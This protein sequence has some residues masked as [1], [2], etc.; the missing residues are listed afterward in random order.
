[1]N[2]KQPNLLPHALQNDRNDLPMQ[3]HSEQNE[4]SVNESESQVCNREVFRTR[5]S[6]RGQKLMHKTDNNKVRDTNPQPANNSLEV[7]SLDML[8]PP[9]GSKRVRKLKTLPKTERPL[10]QSSPIERMATGAPVISATQAYLKPPDWSGEAKNSLCFPKVFGKGRCIE[11]YILNNQ[12]HQPEFITHLAE[13]EI[14]DRYGVMAARL[15]AVFATYA[16]RQYEPWKEPFNLRGTEL[17]KMLGLHRTNRMNKSQKL[18]A[19]ADLGWIVGTLGTVIHWYEGNLDLRVTRKSPIWTILYVEEF[20]Q[21]ELIQ[22]TVELSEVVI[23][24]MPGAWAEKFLN[25]VGSQQ[26]K[27]L[28]QYGVLPRQLF[29]ID[30]HSQ[31]LAANLALYIIQ[32]DRAHKSGAYT[33]SSLLGNVLSQVEIEQAAND[34]RYGWK[35]K[36]KVD[37]AMLVLQDKLSVEIEFDNNT[38]PTWLRPLWALPN[39]LSHLPTR[40]RHQRLL[41]ARRLPDNY[42]QNLW[43]PAKLTFKF[44]GLIQKHLDEPEIRKSE[45]AKSISKHQSLRYS[46]SI[47]VSPSQVDKTPLQTTKPFPLTE[48]SESG[49]LTGAM[50][51]Q[52][53]LAIGMSQRDIAHAIGMSQSWCVTL[54]KKWWTEV[55]S[56]ATRSQA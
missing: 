29:D 4:T 55:D 12:E 26:R 24:V 18:K 1:M 8:P 31:K 21:P 2:N 35:L 49:E 38:Y 19:V 28:Y 51:Q 20:Y 11:F 37:E 40:E 22:G 54:K 16:A 9:R 3:I 44:S 27:A 43:F 36:E 56:F 42:I 7:P 23:R 52:A 46:Q 45:T 53:R 50:V 25:K 41:G 32:N 30:P 33:I 15:H 17:I 5:Q 34:Y 48:V 10:F 6:E 47:E 13:R 39:E 14:L